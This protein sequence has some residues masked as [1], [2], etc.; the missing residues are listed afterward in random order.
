MGLFT[1]KERGEK[2]CCACGVELGVF[3]KRKLDDGYLCKECSAKLSPFSTYDRNNTRE[4]ALA[5]LAYREENKADVAAFNLTKTLGCDPR[6]L[7]D[8]DAGKFMVTSANDW[9]AANPDVISFSQ[10][11]GAETKV[12]EHKTEIMREKEDGTHESYD[13]KRYEV[14]HDVDL[15]I[16]LNHPWITSITIGIA[17]DIDEKEHSAFADAKDRAAEIAGELLDARKKAREDAAAA[18][19][20]KPRVVCPTCGA[21]TDSSTGICEY[22][23][24]ALA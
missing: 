24:G 19:K 17:D 18:S 4:K 3:G 6:I 23:G 21:S 22:C 20:P 16:A 2:V 15:V 1:K 8:E 11:T 9:Q 12:T 10:L 14:S 7:M 5:E 13:P